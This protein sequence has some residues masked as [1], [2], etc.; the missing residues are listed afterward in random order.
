M[1]IASIAAAFPAQRVTNADLLR[2]FA[3]ANQDLPSGQ[4]AACSDRIAKFLQQAGSLVRLYRSR[5][6]QERAYPILRRAI[7]QALLEADVVPSHLDLLVYCGVGR[8]FLEPAT[9]YFV[10][11]DLGISCDCFDIL[12]A[13][14]SWVRAL[15]VVYHLFASG[16]HATALV[17]NAEFNVYE[18]GYPNIMKIGSLANLERT[19]PAYTIG[20]AATATVLRKSSSNWNFRFRSDPRALPLCTV[21]LSN[22][23]EFSPHQNWA[24]ASNGYNTFMCL[25][26]V[27]TRVAARQ[28]LRFVQQTYREPSAFDKWFPHLAMG[29]GYRRAAEI[30]GLNGKIYTKTFARYGN[31]VSA[32]IPVA[33]ATAASEN[34]LRRSD[35]IVLCPMSAGM[36]MALVDFSY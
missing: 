4:R 21:P 1:I 24:L 10:A 14:M 29:T 13:C 30:L 6:A 11:N 15:Y 26:E 17:V 18:F 22:Y 28:M 23:D 3:A 19:L 27:L 16:H 9:A 8:G 2:E 31:V 34:E 20:E 35:R 32:S 33:M 25:G 12:D 5:A 7:D 36:S